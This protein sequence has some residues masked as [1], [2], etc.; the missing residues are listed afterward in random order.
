MLE[1]PFPGFELF[2]EFHLRIGIE[3]TPQAHHFIK[4]S[5][6][7][8]DEEYLAA[9]SLAFVAR[10]EE[11]FVRVKLAIHTGKPFQSRDATGRGNEVTY[12]PNSLEYEHQV[13]VIVLGLRPKLKASRVE[14][15]LQT[16]KLR[17]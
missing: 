2:T 17:T 8:A 3:P 15:L 7:T 5:A 4:C 10:V 9:K 6:I 13:R 11:V 1:D 16:G 14:R 12:G